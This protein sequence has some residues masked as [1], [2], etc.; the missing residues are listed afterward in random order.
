MPYILGTSSRQHL[1]GVHPHLVEVVEQAI[2]L[3]AQ[4]FTVMEGVRSLA[5]EKR[6]VAKG[7]SK[8]LNSKHLKQADGYGHA[9]DLV[10]WYGGAAHWS[11]PHIYPI[12]AAMREAAIH[13]GVAIRWGGVWDR[14]LA[15]LG[16]TP[17]AIEQ[18]VREYERR[19]P[20]PDFLDGVH[21]ELH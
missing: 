1:I 12:A 6:N 16:N 14:T 3:T 19:H 2:R 17:V 5:Q 7:V 9:V 15:E 21:F 10:P 11:W 20:G 4:D 18:A 13:R 8:T